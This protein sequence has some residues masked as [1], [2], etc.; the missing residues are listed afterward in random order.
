M[1]QFDIKDYEDFKTI[2]GTRT[3]S[4]G[5]IQNKILLSFWMH[6]FKVDKDGRASFHV[7][8]LDTLYQ[9][10][11]TGLNSY[12]C[13]HIYEDNLMRWY[14]PDLG[15]RFL[16]PHTYNP[17][18]DERKWGTFNHFNGDPRF[19][20][21]INNNSGHIEKMKAGK[22]MRLAIE[23]AGM[24]LG[25]QTMLYVCEEFQRRWEAKWAKFTN[26]EL[27]V[28]K[29]FEAIYDSNRHDGDFHSCMNNRM[30]WVYYRDCVNASAAYLTNAENKIVARCILFHGVKTSDG[31]EHNYAER[32]Y[33]SNPFAMRVLNRKLIEEGYC[34]LYKIVGAGCHDITAIMDINGKRLSNPALTIPVKIKKNS[35]LSFQ[36]TFAFYYPALKIAA[37]M[38]D[39]QNGDCYRIDHTYS[40]LGDRSR[41]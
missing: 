36:D 17:H 34:D 25:E 13:D 4:R 27:H 23:T 9:A 7:K 1:L 2:F 30:Q 22:F 40:H 28:D 6:R 15:G 3:S 31:V 8:T 21:Y 26:L 37:N 12:N 18:Y 10:V 20:V 24:N 16:L 29:N 32:V 38:Y 33:G 35:I 11:I 39:S 14:M 19:I 5:C 41:Y